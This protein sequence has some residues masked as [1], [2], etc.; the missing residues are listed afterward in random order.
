MKNYSFMAFSA[1]K[2]SSEGGVVK[3]YIGIAPV[4]VIATN[5]TKSELET[6]YGTTLE[7]DVEYTGVQES[8]GKSVPFARIDLI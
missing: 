4:T 7:K 5:P 6:I 8:N 2:E 1:G 3:R